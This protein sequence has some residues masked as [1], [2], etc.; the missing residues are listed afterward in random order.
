MCTYYTLRYGI[1]HDITVIR[2]LLLQ[3][4]SLSL[5]PSPSLTDRLSDGA[6]SRLDYYG[7]FKRANYIIL[8]HSFVRS[9]T[10]NNCVPG[11]IIAIMFFVKLFAFF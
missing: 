5:S 7:D 6:L 9:S 3:L 10:L 2:V 11:S 1:P 8:L 4:F